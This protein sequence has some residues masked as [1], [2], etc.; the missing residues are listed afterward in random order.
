MKDDS[1]RWKAVGKLRAIIYWG[2]EKRVIFSNVNVAWMK[3][4][5]GIYI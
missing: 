2:D 1:E 5:L 4:A 3:P